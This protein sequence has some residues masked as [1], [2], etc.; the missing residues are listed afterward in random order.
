MLATVL[1]IPMIVVITLI[2][3]YIYS[4]EGMNWYTAFVIALDV[5]IA[6]GLKKE[7]EKLKKFEGRQ[8]RQD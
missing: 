8:L 4:V 5:L 2:G 6:I 3:L 7:R 1:F